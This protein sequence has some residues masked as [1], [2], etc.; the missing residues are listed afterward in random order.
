MSYIS[1][2]IDPLRTGISGEILYHIDAHCITAR[3]VGP[4]APVAVD[5]YL[6]ASVVNCSIV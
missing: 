3:A 1:R 4:G 2:T 5:L 6:E